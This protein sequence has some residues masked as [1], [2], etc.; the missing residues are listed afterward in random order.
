MQ[1]DAVK[2]SVEEENGPRFL[3]V[4]ERSSQDVGIYIEE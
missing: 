2:S 3:Y 1:C 4:N